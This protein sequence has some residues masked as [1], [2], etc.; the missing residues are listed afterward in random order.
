MSFLRTEVIESL[1]II[2]NQFCIESLLTLNCLA[3]YCMS[4]LIRVTGAFNKNRDVFQ[5][6]YDS[7]G[8]EGQ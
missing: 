8:F 7:Q 3:I 6:F 5:I 2:F 1:S 4:L